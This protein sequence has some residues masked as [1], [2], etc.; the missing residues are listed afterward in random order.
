MT[1]II[2]AALAFAVLATSAEAATR[3]RTK[4]Q[5]WQTAAVAASYAPIVRTGPSWA[6]PNECFTD[7]GYGRFTPCSGSC[8]SSR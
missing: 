6:G 2:V 8:G 3:K 1:R 7:E 4:A 5:G